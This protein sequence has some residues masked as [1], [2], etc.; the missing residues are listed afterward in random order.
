MESLRI[1]PH[2]TT[3]DATVSAHKNGEAETQWRHQAAA[4]CRQSRTRGGNMAVLL[5]AVEDDAEMPPAA[6]ELNIPM[7]LKPR[8]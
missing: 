5:P 6:S 8:L 3:F 7:K 1:P 2:A 4:H